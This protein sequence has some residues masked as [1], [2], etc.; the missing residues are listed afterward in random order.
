MATANAMDERLETAY[1]RLFE[2]RSAPSLVLAHG[3]SRL[4]ARFQSRILDWAARQGELAA[5]AA[6]E[7]ASAQCAA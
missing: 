1:L 7:P 5:E 6:D 2:E 3:R 4:H